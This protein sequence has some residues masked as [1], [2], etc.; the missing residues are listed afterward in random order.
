MKIESKKK[1]F[2]NIYYPENSIKGIINI[3]VNGKW[4]FLQYLKVNEIKKICSSFSYSYGTILNIE[5][6]DD[7]LK[8][9]KTNPE[10][11]YRT[12]LCPKLSKKINECK[13]VFLLP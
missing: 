7:Y 13:L 3:F 2:Q 4:S 11:V 5:E 6:D 8:N 10:I 9:I 12:L 1:Y